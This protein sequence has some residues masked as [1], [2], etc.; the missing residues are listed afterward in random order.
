MSKNDKP[1][2]SIL[3][4]QVSWSY[5]F[6]TFIAIA[7]VTTF[8]IL[9]FYDTSFSLI[10]DTILL[11]IGCVFTIISTYYAKDYPYVIQAI[12]FVL[13]GIFLGSTLNIFLSIGFLANPS[14]LT[15]FVDLSVVIIGLILIFRML[16]KPFGKLETTF[17]FEKLRYVFLGVSVISI[18]YALA[19]FVSIIQTF[20]PLLPL[21]AISV[22]SI[23]LTFSLMVNI[24]KSLFLT[25][26][27][28]F[29]ERLLRILEEAKYK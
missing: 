3:D 25:G 26:L 17:P 16:K 2:S 6:T 21:E 11:P 23:H 29:L 5:A 13:I 8:I 19:T 18:S 7:F 20:L 12:P 24:F 27:F 1:K 22:S 28:S 4:T 9:H 10:P 14:I 15:V